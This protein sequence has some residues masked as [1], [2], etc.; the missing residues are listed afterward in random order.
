[1]QPDHSKKIAVQDRVLDAIAGRQKAGAAVS[2]GIGKTLIGLRDADRIL[3]GGR[4]V[5]HLSATTKV[6]LVAAP[7]T[8]I[9]DSWKSEM[10]K[11]G[12]KYLLRYFDFTT[13]RSLKKKTGV[14]HKIYLD[15]PQN[16]KDS[17]RA[18]LQAHL[19]RGKAILGLTGTPPR[20]KKGEKGKLMKEFW[21]VVI[22]FTTDEAVNAGILNDY[23][24]IVHK[25]PL[26]KIQT[27]GGRHR[28]EQEVYEYW[29]KLIQRSDHPETPEDHQLNG[30]ML[31]IQRMQALMKFATKEEYLIKLAAQFD[32]KCLLFVNTIEQAERVAQYCHHSK[33][34]TVLNR[35]TLELFRKGEIMR[36]SCVGQL[37]EGI[38][39]PGLRVGIIWH[40]FGNERKASQKIG[41]FLRLN[42]DECATVHV[43]CYEGTVD[44]NWVE[45]ALRD[46]DQDKI[47][48]MDG[49][50]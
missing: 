36:L 3:D 16:L 2:M 29:T 19:N 10:E 32:E 26:G 14:Y 8:V 6:F 41:R 20:Y 39:I 31:R 34:T 5:K 28:T 50:F 47:I 1:M 48:Y 38:N 11:F 12:L 4:R 33:Q 49:L 40:A 43:L 27:R 9:L 25:L 23:K 45:K 13:Y 35:A 18:V 15:E 44:E 17:H 22:D 21:P 46:F 30:E 24:I 42:P 7:T 37:S